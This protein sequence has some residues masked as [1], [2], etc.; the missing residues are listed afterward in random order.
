VDRFLIERVRQI[1]QLRVVDGK[2]VERQVR[3]QGQVAQF[4]AT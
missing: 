2:S 1:H 3:N 4:H